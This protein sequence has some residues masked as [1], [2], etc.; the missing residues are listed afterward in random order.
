MKFWHLLPLAASTFAACNGHEELCGKKYSE[1]TFVG[2]HDSA[3][4]GETPTHNQYVSVADQLNLG[5]RF[6]QAQTHKKG[7]AV[8]LCHTYC[9]ELDA[10]TLQSYLQ[11]VASFMNANPNEV[12]T[13]LLTNG[14]SI[15]VE[16]FDAVF[17][18]T[19]LK[20]YVYHPQ[21]VVAKD[22]WPTLQQLLDAKTRL[23]VFMGTFNY[24]NIFSM[25]MFA[26]IVL[27]DRLPRG[28]VQS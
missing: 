18:A 22:Q 10:G 12:V 11:Q 28:S 15:P 14:D 23:L 24:M 9:W 25:D 3:F 5:V 2:S 7:N 4:V 13:L 21:G 19:G 1:V 8:E 20:Q 17:E 26:D 6:L 16:Q 27:M